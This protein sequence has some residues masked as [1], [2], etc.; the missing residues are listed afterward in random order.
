MNDR[1]RRNTEPEKTKKVKRVFKFSL[2]IICSNYLFSESTNQHAIGEIGSKHGS[3]FDPSVPSTSKSA[4]KSLQATRPKNRQEH[5][6]QQ[7]PNNQEDGG[8][9]GKF[10]FSN[11]LMFFW[12]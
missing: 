6:P 12:N 2:S 8:E 10:H 5:L 9:N 3:E 1:E 7:I 11:N 4:S